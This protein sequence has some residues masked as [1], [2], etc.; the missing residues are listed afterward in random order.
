MVDG[1]DISDI[2]GCWVK[3]G[4]K[5]FKNQ[6][7]NL[8]PDLDE[9][10]FP[11][12]KIF[13]DIHYTDSY[14]KS[15]FKGA[16][17]AGAFE[18]SRGCPYACTYCTNDYVRSL[19][20]GKGKWRREKSPERIVQEVRMFRDEYGLD[21][22][23]WIDEVMLTD[24]DRL[25]NFRDIY[26]TEIGA[27][28]VFMERPENM[29][30]EKVRTIK[31]AGAQMVSIGIES[32]DESIRK[33]LLSRRQSQA[34]IVSAF[35]TAKKHGLTTHAFTMIGFPGEETDSIKK[36]YNLISE[37]QPD[38]VQAAI[39]FL[40]ERQNST[41]KLLTKD[42]LIP[43]HACRPTTIQ[44]PHLIFRKRRS[45]SFYWRDM[46]LPTTRIDSLVILV[47]LRYLCL[48]LLFTYHVSLFAAWL[49]GKTAQEE[50]GFCLR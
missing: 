8:I 16:S 18:G 22:V 25:R 4:D 45:S 38:T 1:S 46:F 5:I 7:R 11:H 9:L 40:S 50:G 31:Q 2:H 41:K 24:I 13:D 3:K 39:F 48:P 34:T 33:N 30:D 20:S 43:T 47:C 17:I 19:Y 21:C 12:W 23:Y 15:L 28:F 49:F 14:V 44:N 36:T 29:T 26:S 10:P 32:G 42:C 27:P 37:S 35:K 6:M